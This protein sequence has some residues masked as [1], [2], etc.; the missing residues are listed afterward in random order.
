MLA[1]KAFTKIFKKGTHVKDVLRKRPL[2]QDW[3]TDDLITLNGLSDLESLK[4]AVSWGNLAPL[5]HASF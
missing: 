1:I 2:L 5:P 3:H 4:N